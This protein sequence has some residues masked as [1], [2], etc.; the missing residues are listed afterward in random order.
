M[1]SP[2]PAPSW[3][4][5]ALLTEVCD[6]LPF[7]S[8]FSSRIQEEHTKNKTSLLC[9][10]MLSWLLFTCFGSSLNNHLSCRNHS[11]IA[12][13]FPICNFCSP[14]ASSCSFSDLAPSH[15]ISLSLLQVEF[16]AEMGDNVVNAVS[17]GRAGAEGLRLVHSRLQRSFVGYYLDW[18]AQV[19]QG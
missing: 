17:S 7:K 6:I 8:Q 5:N 3:G 11:I 19:P 13:S 15:L 14:C 18:G 12:S 1:V 9:S 16:L 4:H 10:S 2:F